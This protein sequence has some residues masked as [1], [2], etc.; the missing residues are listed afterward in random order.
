MYSAMSNSKCGRFFQIL[1]LS[2]N[3]LTLLLCEI[4]NFAFKCLIKW[5][6]K[7]TLWELFT[8]TFLV[9]PCMEKHFPIGNK[10]ICFSISKKF[11]H[12]KPR[13][14]NSTLVS[15]VTRYLLDEVIFQ[16]ADRR[17]ADFRTFVWRCNHFPQ[18]IL[19]FAEL[20]NTPKQKNLILWKLLVVLKV[21]KYGLR[22]LIWAEV[23]PLIKP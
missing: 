8:C 1:W 9:R 14:G 13:D 2:Q 10:E 15:L 5:F 12:H 11:Y 3:V 23:W 17:N 20:K 19:S 6:T 22:V 7:K 4:C 18:Q 21:K 16:H